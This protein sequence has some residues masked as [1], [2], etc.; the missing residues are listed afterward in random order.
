MK[1]NQMEILVKNALIRTK[2]SGWAW[3]QVIEDR[4]KE[5]S[6][7]EHRTIGSTQSKQQGEK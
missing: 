3:Q 6:R 1:K 7:L 5:T 4:G 2:L